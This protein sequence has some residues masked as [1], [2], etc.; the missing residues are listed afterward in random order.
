MNAVCHS[1]GDFAPT[2]LVDQMQRVEAHAGFRRRRVRPVLVL[3]EIVPHGTQLGLGQGFPPA[4]G[5]GPLCVK[6][7]AH[8]QCASCAPLVGSRPVA[9]RAGG[10]GTVD[11]GS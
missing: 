8:H 6:T 1:R 2:K 9:P 5:L 3:L 10:N 7:G 4:R 11:K